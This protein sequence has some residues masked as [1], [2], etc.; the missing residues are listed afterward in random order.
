MHVLILGLSVLLV[1][2]M[3][4]PVPANALNSGSTRAIQFWYTSG[5]TVV[6]GSEVWTYGGTNITMNAT[7]S[8]REG[9]TIEE[10][11]EFHVHMV[12]PGKDTYPAA[13]GTNPIPFPQ[14]TAFYDTFQIIRDPERCVP[15]NNSVG[16]VCDVPEVNIQHQVVEVQFIRLLEFTDSSGNGRYDEG[17]P[18]L[19]QFSLDNRSFSYRI[20]RLYGLN[21]SAGLLDLPI[22]RHTSAVY[23]DSADGWVGQNEAVFPL[24]DGISLTASADGPVDLTLVGYQWFS[25]RSFQGTSIGLGQLK[26]DLAIE[27]Y[28]LQGG[29]SRL[30]LELSVKSFSQQSSTEWSLVPSTGGQALEMDAVNTS[31]V[32]A[33]SSTVIA[34]GV[35]STVM[36]TVA[37]IDALSTRVLLSYP[38]AASILHDPVL[39][40]ADK[41]LEG[42]QPFVP[43]AAPGLVAWIA[44]GMT[45]SATA[46]AVVLIER[47]KR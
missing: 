22:R 21:D 9:V 31:A 24:F 18:V 27:S 35:S 6:G 23:G 45:A 26:M 15:A 14:I 20:P 36:S 34:D 16:F 11:T 33:W 46:C 10:I 12:V 1:V 13:N 17:E 28:P 4:S 47:R 32:F 7:F 29:N 19:S 40:I 43:P 38:G 8:S 44:F 39:G 37:P 30:A 2:V 5:T 25:S 3:F 42:A 41:R